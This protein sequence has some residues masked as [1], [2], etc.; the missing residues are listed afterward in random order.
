[1]R[2]TIHHVTTGQRTIMGTCFPICDQL[3]RDQRADRRP[4]WIITRGLCNGTAQSAS[5][6]RTLKAAL[7][8]W[9]QIHPDD[10][11]PTKNA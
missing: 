7:E 6:Y 10:S 9:T 2:T 11:T 8:A 4:S 1:M 3:D 5:E